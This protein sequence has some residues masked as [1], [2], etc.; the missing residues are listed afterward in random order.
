MPLSAAEKVATIVGIAMLPKILPKYGKR[1]LICAGCA[2]GIVGQ[3]IFLLN[4]TSVPLGVLTCI[5]RGFV[6]APFYGVQ[7]SLPGDAI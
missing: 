7:Y 1:N 5:M 2:L 3:L 4:I 6:I